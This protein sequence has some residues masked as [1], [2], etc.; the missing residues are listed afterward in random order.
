VRADGAHAL[1]AAAV[2][3]CRA[4]HA[5]PES[6]RARARR[7]LDA[8]LLPAVWGEPRPLAVEALH[9]HGEP[10]GVAQAR[11]GRFEPFAVGERWGALWDTTWMRM[12]G[13]VPGEWAGE[14]VVAR[15]G[16][17][18]AGQT[19]FGAEALLWH[20]DAPVQ[21]ISPDHS[22][23]LIARPARGGEDV[24]L[25]IEAAAN[26]DIDQ[27][28]A[29]W[30]LLMPD[31]GGA[32]MLELR[33][34]EICVVR[35][36]VEALCTDMEIVFDLC[37][38]L[39]QRRARTGA[40]L[41]ALRR[42]CMLVDPENLTASNVAAA[43]APLD[44][45]LR[46]TGAARRHRVV[47]QGHAHIDTAWLWPLRE[48][49]RK[50][51]RS[52][53]TVLSLMD[54]DPEFRFAASQMVH[55]AWMREDYPDL[56]AR[57]R[58][59][60]AEGRWEVVGGMW[61]EA[62]CNI[63]SAESLVRQV[64]HG[65][66]FAEEVLGVS[67][68]VGWLPDTFGFPATLP[69]ILLQSGMSA[70]MTQK[71]SWNQ[72]TAF[73]H[74][75]FWWEGIDG[76]RVLTHMPPVAT[77]NGD[78]SAEEVLRSET[79]FRDPGAS[80]ASLYLFGLGDGG[81]GPSREM[82]QRAARMRD[83][84]GL[85]LLEQGTSG[86]FFDAVA[87][88]DGERLATWRGELYLERHRGVFTSQARIKHDNREAERLLREA[89][90]WSA[91]RPGGLRDYYPSAQLDEAWKL[92]LLHQFHDILPGTSI[93][94]V[95]EDAR[96]DHA[97]VHAVAGHAIDTALEAIA[98]TVDTEAMQR[99]YAVFNAAS[100]SRRELVEIG[101][102]L[103]EVEVPALGWAAVDA[104]TPHPGADT[105]RATT[106]SMEN[107]LLRIEWG[108]DG[109][110]TSIHD[111]R[112]GREVL[113]P[114]AR[115]NLL[116][117]FRDHPTDYDAWEIDA[118]DLRMPTGITHCDTVEL[119]EHGPQR[120]TMR[121]TRRH[122][123]STYTQSTTL[124][125]GSARIDFH[126]TVD[127]QESHRLL[128][129]AFPVAVRA[130]TATYDVGFG[131]VQRPTHENTAADAAQFEVPAH[132]WADL[133]QPDHGVALLNRDKHGYD[134][135]GN[136]LRLSLLRAPT[137]PDP[138]ADRGIHEID[139]ALLPHDGDATAARVAHHAEAYGIPLRAVATT[140]HRGE[141]PT[142]GTLLHLDADGAVLV[143]AVK[144]S[145]RG[146]ALIVRVCEVGGGGAS[147]ALSA[148]TQ[149][150]LCD[151]RE[152]P[153][154]PLDPHAPLTLGPYQLATLRFEP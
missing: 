31:P 38:H 60:I 56:F 78:V 1:A 74:S 115:A 135:R 41:D 152:R 144:K 45:A 124:H 96:R 148:T 70:F 131:T 134:V 48:T 146:E 61:V 17:G 34:A 108:A 103:H 39:D 97:R 101:S 43:R 129:V 92:T 139:Y 73:P 49:R 76:S 42:A 104:A 40:L 46:V 83:V 69:Q 71:I 63:A 141:L 147:I 138:R 89:E 75:S 86:G 62:D 100:A 125:A 90:T 13:A 10:I 112:S 117:I 85:P 14:E 27:R 91:L 9:V 105:V 88:E 64:L 58:E 153:H 106:T 57:I 136:T 21:G 7:L 95:Y 123:R 119:I 20:G 55:Y 65:A 98:A 68:T 127:W 151:L 110:L 102:N 109:L 107:A 128:K 140:A 99:P 53:S 51:A 25:L 35:R 72:T 84:E 33:R 23:V 79:A 19:G 122:G 37:A 67:P 4:V 16:L 29:T 15:I 32:P 80:S 18:Y 36:D 118:D 11:A 8:Y 150:A 93:H 66:L 130:A 26:P 30:P 77:Y 126:A 133:S 81:G 143:T 6:I 149:A 142:T 3:S 2:S 94:W 121:V 50:C 82:L 137:A 47:A 54:E 132:R 113:E 44:D 12:R 5:S 87:R 116:Q 111:K 120:A 59:R 24:D 22:S 145:E 28:A 114:G 52:F 154:T